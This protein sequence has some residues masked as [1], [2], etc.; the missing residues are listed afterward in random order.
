MQRSM[1]SGLHSSRFIPAAEKLLETVYL[2]KA[3]LLLEEGTAL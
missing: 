1:S 2:H 3:E